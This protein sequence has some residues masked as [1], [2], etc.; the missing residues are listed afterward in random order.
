MRKDVEVQ[1]EVQP[2]VEVQPQVRDNKQPKKLKWVVS[3]TAV[4][5][6]AKG[7]VNVCG[8]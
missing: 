2:T 7:C 8:F 3:G 5:L 4:S 6:A 1:P